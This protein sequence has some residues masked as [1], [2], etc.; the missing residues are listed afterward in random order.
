MIQRRLMRQP[1]VTLHLTPD[2]SSWPNLV[3]R[4]FAELTDKW[5]KRGTHRSI[6]KLVVSIR[7]WIANWMRRAQALCVAQ[8]R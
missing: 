1:H 6:R 2:H 4:W 5:L 8:D 3:E 7:T